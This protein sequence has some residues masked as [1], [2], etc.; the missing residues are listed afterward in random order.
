MVFLLYVA[1]TGIYGCVAVSLHGLNWDLMTRFAG[2]LF[3]SECEP[4]LKLIYVVA[5]ISFIA[6]LSFYLTG[7][8][9]DP[10]KDGKII[11]A[12]LISTVFPVL[13]GHSPFYLQA[14]VETSPTGWGGADRNI[15]VYEHF[16]LMLSDTNYDF[17]SGESIALYILVPLSLVMI[18]IIGRGLLEKSVIKKLLSMSFQT[19]IILLIPSLTAG[20][21]FSSISFLMLKGLTLIIIL[22]LLRYGIFIIPYSFIIFGIL[23]ALG[24]KKWIFRFKSLFPII[25]VI[26]VILVFILICSF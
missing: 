7:F 14:D 21:I 16:H 3:H 15:E 19:F 12:T 23:C 17:Y 13:L 1:F 5:P 26:L 24:F 2:E 22:Y 11:V 20:V 6:L 25:A 4:N 18:L 8:I 9:K 10:L